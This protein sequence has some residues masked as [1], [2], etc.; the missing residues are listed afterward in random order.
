MRQP[1]AT[2]S[3]FPKPENRAHWERIYRTKQESEVSWHQDEPELSLALVCA[4]S[5]PGASVIDIG[6]GSSVL[7]GRLVER[8][9]RGCAVL[10][11]SEAAL[12]RARARIG[13]NACQIKWILADITNAPDDLGTFDVW[14]DRAVFHFLVTPEARDAYAGLA[15]RTVPVGGELI[16]GT[17]ALNGPEKCSGLEIERYDGCKLST[18]LGSGFALRREI[19]ETHVTPWGTPQQFTYAIF[20]RVADCTEG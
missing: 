16:I 12:G 8:G 10:D 17:F 5:R 11:I 1:S 7:I 20:D 14:H 4:F 3:L 19:Q 18:V 2:D 13:S 9:F 6:G 15:R